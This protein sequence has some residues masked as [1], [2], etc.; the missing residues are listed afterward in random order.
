MGSNGCNF[1]SEGG[2]RPAPVGPA[3]LLP[4]LLRLRLKFSSLSL[5]YNEFSTKCAT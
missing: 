1:A 4:S 5:N 3:P 2:S